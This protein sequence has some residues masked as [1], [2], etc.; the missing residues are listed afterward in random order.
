MNTITRWDP[1]KEME[2]LQNRLSNLFGRTPARLGDGK[3]ESIT[4]AEWAPLVDITEDDKGQPFE[5]F[6]TLGKAGG[7]AMADAEAM[8]RLEQTAGKRFGSDEDPLLVS[9]RSGARESMPGMLD[10]I[11]NVGLDDRSVEGLAKATDNERFAWDSY[12]RLIQMFGNVVQGVA[13][14]KFEQAIEQA[15]RKAGVESDAELPVQAL[16]E[17]YRVLKPGG[18]LFLHCD[19]T[20]SHY[21]KVLLDAIFGKTTFQNEI[22]W[23]YDYG[24][25]TRR[26]WPSSVRKWAPVAASQ[27]CI[28]HSPAV[29]MCFPSGLKAAL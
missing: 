17:L 9:V 11:L 22:V 21:L 27:T 5:V 25:R 29:T 2:D 18:S 6:I 23:A 28:G 7:S 24:A 10:T 1:M 26:T 3:E 19:P 20:A 13:G 15:K 12:R 8:G 16:R 14:E 4:V